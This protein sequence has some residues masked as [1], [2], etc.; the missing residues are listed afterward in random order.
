MPIP[1]SAPGTERP[2]LDTFFE[3]TYGELAQGF[4]ASRVFP[5]MPVPTTTGKF[6]KIP[7]EELL[8]HTGFIDR[9]PGAGYWRDN[10]TFTYDSYSTQEYGVEEVIDDREAAMYANFIDAERMATA[11]AANKLLTR[12]EMRCAALFNSTNYTNAGAV[13]SKAN[14]GWDTAGGLPVTDTEAAVQKVYDLTGMKPNCLIINWKTFRK[15]RANPQVVDQVRS[16]GAGSASKASDVTSDMLSNVFDLPY[17]FVAGGSKNTAGPGAAAAIS[18]IWP[19][20]AIVA[21]IAESQDMR[22]PCVGR[23][24]HWAADGSEFGGKIETYRDEPIRSDIVRARHETG[25]KLLYLEM[26]CM[27]LSVIS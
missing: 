21:R 12:Q 10:F 23:Q 13:V 26:A 24:F 2:E 4:I 1:S 5:V 6:G 7:L 27:I 15:T 22:E 20:H 17:V 11:R 8:K 19:N 3:A 9:N 14:G 18:Q 25:E 16:S